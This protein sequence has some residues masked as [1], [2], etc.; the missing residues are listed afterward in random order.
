MIFNL[1]QLYYIIFLQ[2]IAY[3]KI[4]KQASIETTKNPGN[5]YD[6]NWTFRITKTNIMA[7]SIIWIDA[8]IIFNNIKVSWE[9]GKIGIYIIN[10]ILFEF[11]NLN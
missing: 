8:K 5:T 9:N 3:N 10:Y 7:D 4:N 11:K 1:F 2:S 6:G